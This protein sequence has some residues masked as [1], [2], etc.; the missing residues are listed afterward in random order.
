MKNITIELMGLIITN[1]S[2][3]STSEEL[4]LKAQEI[5]GGKLEDV[6][7]EE[8]TSNLNYRTY[9]P[10]IR[11]A[12]S[13]AVETVFG[14]LREK[15]V[16]KSAKTGGEVVKFLETEAKHIKRAKAAGAVT[17]AQ[18]LELANAFVKANDWC[19][20]CLGASER[21]KKLPAEIVAQAENMLAEDDRDWDI[22]ELKLQAQLGDTFVLERDGEDGKPSAET[23]G[24]ALVAFRSALLKASV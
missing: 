15:S 10:K 1:L 18:L 2:V 14:F 16:T 8:A 6:A 11:R 9:Y 12:L 24:A 3:P 21:S 20:T 17:D 7:W 22:T 4:N 23:L 13:D 5:N 19:K